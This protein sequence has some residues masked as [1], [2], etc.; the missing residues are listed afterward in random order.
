M[1]SFNIQSIK[2]LNPG[3]TI[4]DSRINGLGCRCQKEQRSFIFKYRMHGRQRLLTLGTFGEE[5]TIQQARDEVIK[6]HADIRNGTDPALTKQ[7]LRNLPNVSVASEL[8]LNEIQHKR[9]PST[10]REY[11]RLFEKEINPVIGKYQI[12]AVTGADI[13]NLHIKHASRPYQA[14]R[15]LA[16]LSSFFSWCERNDH[17]Q[18][19]TNPCYGIEKY[20]EHPRDPGI[21][22]E[23]ELECL[24]TAIRQYD[25]EHYYLSPPSHQ[26]K[27][28]EEQ[29][30]NRCTPYVTGAIRMIILSG[31][32]KNEILH[33]KWKDIDLRYKF[34][35]LQSSKTGQK[36][37]YLSPPMIELLNS[38]PRMEGN[39][40]VFCGKKQG[41]PLDNIKDAWGKIRKAAGME[42]W[43]LHDFRHNYASTA[44]LD[45]CHLMVV[46]KI[47][48]HKN[49]KTTERYAH[50]ANTPVQLANDAVSLQIAASLYAGE[51][52][53]SEIPKY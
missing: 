44:V 21:L 53:N 46:G 35:R 2:A 33:L 41:Q 3:E 37:I 18:R 30:I 48:G 16:V 11:K 47:L 5:F 13:N 38:I 42:H 20:K 8:Y 25:E 49:T 34:I 15:M 27:E 1:K 9:K 29:R 51:K 40:Y 32:R 26:K 39:P 45:G 17:R 22:T 52:R 12:N 19:K 6:Y 7:K 36:T 43:R 10:H 14:N 50:L 28:V 23:E 24:G 4:W 31:A